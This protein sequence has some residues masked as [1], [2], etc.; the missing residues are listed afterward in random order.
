MSLMDNRKSYRP[1][2]TVFVFNNDVGRYEYI[3]QM[4]FGV[5]YNGMDLRF[6]IYRRMLDFVFLLIVS[7]RLN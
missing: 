2:N 4:L 7:R 1:I 3:R 6:F 5:N